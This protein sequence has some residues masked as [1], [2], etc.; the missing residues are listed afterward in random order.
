MRQDVLDQE[1]ISQRLAHFLRIYSDKSIM[2]PVAHERRTAG[3]RLRLGHLIFMVREYQIAAAAVE[4]ETTAQILVGHGAAFDVPARP[5]R[6][7]GAI[8]AGFAGFGALPECKIHRMALAV[9]HFHPGTGLHILQATA[10][11]MA[12]R[13]EVLNAE[14]YVAVHHI[15]VPLVDERRN[16][17]DNFRHMPRNPWIQ[18]HPTDIQA[19][20]HFKIGLDIATGELMPGNPLPGG[21]IDDFVV[22]VG[23]ILD[24]GDRQSLPLEIAVNDVPDDERPG[25]ADMRMII[26]RHAADVNFDL[27][28]FRRH[29]QFLFPGQRI[30]NL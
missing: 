26:R 7:P 15:G 16:H 1:K 20:H 21:G 28:R 11:Q 23:K 10:A 29:K 8:P 4:I 2:D 24:V 9:V 17:I 13:R 12:V 18:I 14:I 19:V 5:T 27:S 25:V 22:D 30:I 3:E 6:S